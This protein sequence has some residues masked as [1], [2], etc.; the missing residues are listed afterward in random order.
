MFSP[1]SLALRAWLAHSR[2][3]YVL[4]SFYADIVLRYTQ[5]AECQVCFE[6]V[7]GIF[8]GIGQ[9]KL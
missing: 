5:S 4:H 7:K 1:I 9:K 6:E 8:E 2:T 3:R